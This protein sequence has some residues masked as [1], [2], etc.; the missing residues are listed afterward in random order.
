MCNTSFIEY[1]LNFDIITLAETFVDKVE[2]NAFSDYD[3]HFRKSVKLTKK[4]D[5]Q[6]VLY[7]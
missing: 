2:T 4:G 5:H 7:A 3:I 1:I 6:G